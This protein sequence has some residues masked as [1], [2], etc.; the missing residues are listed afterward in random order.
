MGGSGL[1]REKFN[2]RETVLSSD[3]NRLQALASRDNQNFLADAD[4]DDS[5]VP[6]TALSGPCSLAGIAGQFNMALSADQALCWNP[7]DSSL[8]ADDSAYEIARWAAQNLLFANP[9]GSN[10]RIDLVVMTPAMV[11]ADS[12]S[13]NVLV[14]PVARTITPQNVFKTT[15]PLCVPAVVTGTAATNPVPPAVPGGAFAL[16]EVWVPAAA[17]DSTTFTALPRIWRRAPFPL[18]TMNGIV[19]GMRLS[20]DLSV[21]PQ[22]ASTTMFVGG[23]PDGI[24]IARHRMLIDGELLD[25]PLVGTPLQDA[26]AN[27][28]F[29]SAAPAHWN[30]PYYV[31][32]CGGRH[33]PQ[34]ALVGAVPSPIALVESLVPPNADGHPSAAITTPRGVTTTLGAV[35]IGLGFVVA[36]TT[37]RLGCVMDETWTQLGFASIIGP[38]QGV[39]H[40]SVGSGTWEAYDVNTPMF[41]PVVARKALVLLQ[42]GAAS[43]A[44]APDSGSGTAVSPA[45]G[46]VASSGQLGSPA[47]SFARG[48]I[49]LPGGFAN[50]KIWVST[51]GVGITSDLIFYGFEHR[52]PRISGLR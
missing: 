47:S 38:L 3:F 6:I 27:N 19:D 17:P 23:G 2:T 13:R 30:L 24:T 43:A 15:N 26:G 32:A 51:S 35:Y 52:V 28:P 16:F 44:V 7:S 39:Q 33:C 40:V 50:P 42:V 8:T 21:D 4:T 9:N 49:S 1:S 41:L 37:R 10:P 18:G 29:A 5:G 11:D 20:W 31:Y 25:A 14:D 12:Q 36:N 48:V 45:F 46:F 34:A 22:A